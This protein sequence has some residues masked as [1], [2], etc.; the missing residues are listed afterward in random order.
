MRSYTPGGRFDAEFETNDIL[1]AIASDL[2]NPVGTVAQWYVWKPHSNSDAST[3][4]IDSVYDVGSYTVDGSGGRKWRDGVE[5]P[6]IRAVIKQGTAE[7][8]ERG[9]YAPDV[10]HLTLDR[11]E[12]MRHIPD[13]LDD[14]DP[15]DRDRVVWKGQ[16]YRPYL[17]Q[18]QGII[19]ERFTIIS[20]DCQQVMPEE[21]VNDPQFQQYSA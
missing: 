16:V 2:T 13:V 6:V 19:A 1:S 12:L 4:Q 3:T 15:L 5:V 8:N 7:L 9:L 18:E 21:M 11:D 10:L 20:F 14:P 17:S